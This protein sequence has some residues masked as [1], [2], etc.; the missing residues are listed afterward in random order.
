MSSPTHNYTVNGNLRFNTKPAYIPQT[1][2]SS[3]IGVRIGVK[4]GVTGMMMLY[5][6]KKRIE[7]ME[8]ESPA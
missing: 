3:K 1:V 6:T 8:N 4:T 7:G 2:L 5:M